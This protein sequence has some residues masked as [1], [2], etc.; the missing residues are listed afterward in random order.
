MKTIAKHITAL[1][2]AIL[3]LASTVSFTVNTH[4]CM[5]RP[6][7]RSVFTAAKSCGMEMLEAT[8]TPKGCEKVT[9]HCCHDEQHVVKG[10]KE[11]KDSSIELTTT[12][13]AVLTAYVLY[14]YLNLF[15]GL[16]E[17]VVPFIGYSPHKVVKPIHKL[18]QVYLI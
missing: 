10:Q 9:Q 7:D 8:E 11:L 14:T 3:V 16:K 15:E 1:I 2:L 13:Q 4:Y 12:Q 6:M 17:N 5:G 18:H